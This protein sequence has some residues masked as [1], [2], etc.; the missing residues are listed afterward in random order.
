[1]DVHVHA[2]ITEQ[3]RL[4]GVNVL[5]AIEDEANRLPDEAILQ[6]ALALDRVIF[7]QD[8]RFKA[9]AEEWQR[10]GRQF[11]GLLFGRQLGASI[12]DFVRDL[13]LIGL[14]CD[15]GELRNQ[16]LYLPL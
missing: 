10:Q 9:L 13:E 11:A 7:T 15:P 8:V 1:M 4:R 14:A 12:G 16:V 6:R 3:V 5:T 2:S